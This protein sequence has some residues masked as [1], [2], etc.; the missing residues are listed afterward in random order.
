MKE[1]YNEKT[2]HKCVAECRDLQ[3]NHLTHLFVAVAQARRLWASKKTSINIATAKSKAID[4]L[5]DRFGKALAHHED[6]RKFIKAVM[7]V[8]G[9]K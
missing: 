8:Q 1:S 3:W 4:D 5:A 7:R 9:I 6:P 2:G